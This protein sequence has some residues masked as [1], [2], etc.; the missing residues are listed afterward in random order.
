MMKKVVG[1]VMS[2]IL[3][4]VCTVS[5][6]H[7]LESVEMNG[8]L[9]ENR[10]LAIERLE[11]ERN[12]LCHDIDSNAEAIQRIDYQLEVL[13]VEELTAENSPNLDDGDAAIQ[14]I[15][16]STNYHV[17]WTTWRTMY[18]Y[19]GTQYEIQIIKAK[20]NVDSN[21]Y[22]YP[23]VYNS[24]PLFDS[25]SFGVKDES[26]Y[27]VEVAALEVAKLTSEYVGGTF[28]EGAID[29]ASTI[30]PGVSFVRYFTDFLEMQNELDE[31][32]RESLSPTTK[33]QGTSISCVYSL[34]AVE[35]Y[36]YV[37]IPGYEDEGHQI[38]AYIG[39]QVECAATLSY[40][41]ACVI[42]GE[43]KPLTLSDSFSAVF[44]SPYFL[45]RYQYAVENFVRHRNG[46][47]IDPYH[48]A[49]SFNLT[50]QSQIV[51]RTDITKV[52]PIPYIRDYSLF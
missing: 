16:P 36:L 42:N 33:L 45:T 22:M 39:N 44:S 31:T 3:L 17:K 20:S 2:V 8:F 4:M 19:Y 6:V 51:D 9:D 38:C 40:G 5:P 29:T 10:V 24:N 48:L 41:T 21:N 37:K 18:V 1:L 43:L 49:Y 50:L 30:I 11:M 27:G 34:V 13:G 32:V 47:D 52:I 28:Y 12:R 15:A 25:D 7:A 14:R 26:Q 46:Y 35:E 23:V